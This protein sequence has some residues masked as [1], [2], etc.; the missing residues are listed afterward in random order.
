VTD[1]TRRLEGLTGHGD[2]I[3][4]PGR[5]LLIG[6][7]AAADLVIAD[8]AVSRAHAEVQVVPDGV[9]ARDLGS[10]NGTF[11]N[12]APIVEAIARPGDTLTFG[13]PAFRLEPAEPARPD[14]PP[15]RALA[16]SG[17]IVGDPVTLRRLL[18]LARTLAGRIEPDQ[19]AGDIADLAF[20]V[21]AAD[22]VALLLARGPNREL[23][24]VQS[25][26]RVG[27]AAAVRV[28]RAIAGR[29]AAERRPLLVENALDDATLGSGS[30]V[31][32]RVR[33]AVA[34][35]L[36]SDGETVIGV[37]YAD[38]MTRPDPFTDAEAGALQAF[39]GLAAVS[40]AKLDLTEALQRQTET[41][42]NL[43]RFFAP[44]VAAAIVAAGAPVVAGGDRR[45][46][47]VL[48]NDIRGFTQ[49]AESLA[50]EAVADLLTEFFSAMAEVVFAHGGT[51]DK[52]LGDGLLA[53]WGA[54]LPVEDDAGRALEAARTMQHTVAAL[55]AVWRSRGRPT[56][57][58]GIGLARGE[59]FAGRIG[60]DRR[61]D[62][63]VLGDPVN[64][65]ARLCDT[66]AP[67]E[68][69]LTGQVRE[70]LTDR[71]GL[72]LRPEGAV[73]GRTGAAEVWGDA[74]A[75]VS[76]Q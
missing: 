72:A 52:F 22:R 44:E 43:E 28:P 35:P 7:G 41:R 59:V 70:A 50:P 39:A 75:A 20:E 69:L 55:N 17:D 33:A 19:L 25:R 56:I 57:A 13:L 24:P 40:L 67:G 10:A 60:S 18:A 14:V 53:V 38:R 15:A 12:G 71:R 47:T 26:S 54:P 6:R 68:I 31:A 27:D 48:F 23:V 30:V 1:S 51:L 32:E 4:P 62:Y 65:A 36:L 76:A 66:A 3:V 16:P 37:L 46:V 2:L 5:P 61:L 8:T 45:T 58:I 49:L 73:R 42:R 63:T 11:L 64:L 74:G 9:R 29:A 34:V 21:V